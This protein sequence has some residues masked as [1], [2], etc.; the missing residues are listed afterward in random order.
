MVFTPGGGDPSKYVLGRGKLYLRGDTKLVV[1]SP[2]VAGWRDVGNV[3]AFTVTQEA[4]VKE[5]KSFL[6]GIATIDKQ[7]PVSQKMTIGFTTD[8]ASNWLNLAAFFSGTLNNAELGWVV[9]NTSGTASDFWA[10]TF[11]LPI[12]N[13]YVQTAATDFLYDLW[14]DITLYLPAPFNAEYRALDFASQANQAISVRKAATSRTAT[15]GTLLTEGTHYRIDRKM[16][17]ILFLNVAG[18]IARG[19][20]FQI[21]WAA[22]PDASKAAAADAKLNLIQL[23]TSSG[24]TVGLKFIQ[25]NPNNGDLQTEWGFHKIQLKPEG[26]FGG[27][28][29]DW[30]GLSF[31]G[32]V[33]AISNPPA[34]TSPYGWVLG[35]D[36]YT[37]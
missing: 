27:I 20:T 30:A 35:R 19:D 36:V 37:T 26:E 2:Q 14:I 16:G 21:S 29:D 5:H 6:Q 28:S 32:A 17:R 23:L 24:I 3:T 12:A 31:S 4:E 25:E 10:T 34:G 15:D 7:V 1:A 33:E 13:M 11:S 18:G 9:P 8:E 22:S